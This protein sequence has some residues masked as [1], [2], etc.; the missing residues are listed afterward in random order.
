[1][2]RSLSQERQH[3]KDLRSQALGQGDLCCLPALSSYLMACH[4][5]RLLNISE[6][7]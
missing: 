7:H 5:T 2:E 1:M 3:R 4:L 6:P